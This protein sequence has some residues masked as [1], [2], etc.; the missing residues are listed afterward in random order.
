MEKQNSLAINVFG[1]DNGLT[2]YTQH[3]AGG[4]AQHQSAADRKIRPIP[5]HL[6]QGPKSFTLRPEQAPGVQVLLSSWVH[7]R[8]SAGGPQTRV[9]RDWADRSPGGDAGGGKKQ[10]HLPESPQAASSPLHYLC[11][12]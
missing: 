1:W 7:K 9:P 2:V 4:H 12:L 10:A 6:D 5:L 3:P 11:R 8:G